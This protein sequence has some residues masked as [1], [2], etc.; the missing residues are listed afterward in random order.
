MFEAVYAHAPGQLA[1]SLGDDWLFTTGP[2]LLI[3]GF[4]LK[5]DPL[6][7]P[8]SNLVESR[9]WSQSMLTC[10]STNVSDD[11]TL[12]AGA[13]NGQ[14][15]LL[16]VDNESGE[17]TFERTVLVFPLPVRAVCMS[18]SGRF[19]MA[20]GEYPFSCLFPYKITLKNY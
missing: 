20:G 1:L 16:K 9:P 11:K 5:Q 14:V 10:L 8:K 17:C 7:T 13:L 4:E 18:Q 19:V 3:N 15:L 2:D 6:I 12:A